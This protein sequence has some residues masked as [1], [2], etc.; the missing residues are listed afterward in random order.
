VVLVRPPS[1]APLVALAMYGNQGTLVL[2]NAAGFRAA[3]YV[4][5]AIRNLDQEKL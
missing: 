2:K 3:P 1:L 4:E 5:T